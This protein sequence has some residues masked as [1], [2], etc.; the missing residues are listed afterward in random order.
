VHTPDEDL[1]WMRDVVFPTQ[2][3][4]LACAGDAI[5]GIGAREGT[6]VMQLYVAPE[7]AGQGIGARLLDRMAGES[8]FLDLWAFQR[9]AGARRFYE[10]HGF[11]AV[12]F[13]DG[14]GNEEREPDVR[15]A[16]RTR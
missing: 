12:E 10:R 9:N 5:V 6:R 2:S 15:Y 1:A 4:W 8:A 11:V 3:V 16:R 7:W 14:A 13:T